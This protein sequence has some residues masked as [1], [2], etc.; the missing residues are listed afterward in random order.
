MAGATA[1]ATAALRCSDTTN[2][3]AVPPSASR[4][5]RAR[6]DPDPTRLEGGRRQRLGGPDPGSASTGEIGRE[7]HDEQGAA[8]GE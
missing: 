3:A 6:T 1:G 7:L 2:S 5:T 4:P 8:H